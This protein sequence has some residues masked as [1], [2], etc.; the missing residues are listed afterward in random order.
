M[1]YPIDA[2]HFLVWWLY[3]VLEYF[4]DLSH[5]IYASLA[6]Y[7]EYKCLLYSPK[8][9]QRVRNIHL[10]RQVCNNLIL[11]DQ[12]HLNWRLF[13]V[14]R[15]KGKRQRKDLAHLDLRFEHFNHLYQRK[16]CRLCQHDLLEYR[17]FWTHKLGPGWKSTL[18]R[19]P[20]KWIEMNHDHFLW[21]MRFLRT[22]RM[23]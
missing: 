14:Y 13:V 8:G 5:C 10:D 18:I 15:S 20:R 2:L 9:P 3:F 17:I 11:P 7:Q 12:T 4:L 19:K 16:S 6:L 23:S 22:N 1:L 21:R